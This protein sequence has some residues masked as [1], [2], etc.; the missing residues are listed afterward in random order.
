MSFS[1]LMPFALSSNEDLVTNAVLKERYFANGKP[2]HANFLMGT[3]S[4]S[5]SP[6]RV[7]YILQSTSSPSLIIN[8]VP[9]G[10]RRCL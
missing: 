9:F 2:T 10:S 5:R 7:R 3:L 8:L 1:D 4:I 6:V